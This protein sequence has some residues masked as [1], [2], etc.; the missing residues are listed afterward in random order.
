MNDPVIEKALLCC[1]PCALGMALRKGIWKAKTRKAVRRQG[2][3]CTVTGMHENSN[4]YAGKTLWSLY[5]YFKDLLLHS[6]GKGRKGEGPA[7]SR[8]EQEK[9]RN[10]EILGKALPNSL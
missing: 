1:G 9:R 6:E 8:W 2:E 5:T 10:G 4:R 3:A 7:G